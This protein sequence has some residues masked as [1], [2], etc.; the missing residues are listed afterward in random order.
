MAPS[1]R[2]DVLSLAR[3]FL[4]LLVTVAPHGS[5]ST[6]L[7][8]YAAQP[9]PTAE[10]YVAE[11][12]RYARAREFDKAIDAY[13][14]ALHINPAMATAQHGLG[15]TYLNMGRPADAIEP[16]KAAARLDPQN[17]IVHMTLGIALAALRRADE[18][19]VEMNEARSLAPQ[20][21]RVHNE[22]GNV[23]HNSFGRIDD[24]LASYEEA[25]R[26]DRVA[27]RPRRRR[28]RALCLG[29]G[30]RQQALSRV[31]SRGRRARASRALT[32]NR[33]TRR[34]NPLLL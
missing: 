34:A 33:R 4:L 21:P 14:Q 20:N 6:R 27:A 18:A 9:A 2:A 19:I 3:I 7:Q 8:A 26:L 11:G 5:A 22:L 32:H 28:A 30:I 16:L 17:A 25:R 24:A 13:R 10:S 12:D 23:L 29:Q 15:A 31:P 1:R